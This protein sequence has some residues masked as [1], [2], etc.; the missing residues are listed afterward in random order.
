[1]VVSVSNRIFPPPPHTYTPASGICSSPLVLSLDLDGPAVP[2]IVPIVTNAEAI[3]VNQAWAGHPRLL[4]Q[5]HDPQL[6]PR[7]AP[8]ARR[9]VADPPPPP[10][11]GPD[12][13]GFVKYKGMLNARDDVRF[14]ASLATAP[15][16]TKKK[17]SRCVH[18]PHS[19]CRELCRVLCQSLAPTHLPH[20]FPPTRQHILTQKPCSFPRAVVLV[21]VSFLDTHNSRHLGAARHHPE[22]RARAVSN[23][24]RGPGFGP[25]H[26]P[27]IDSLPNPVFRFIQGG[28]PLRTATLRIAEA[29][30]WC[31]STPSCTCTATSTSLLSI[32]R[33]SLSSKPPHDVCFLIV[34]T[35]VTC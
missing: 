24:D 16:K 30:A 28:R 26:V 9:K 10:H 2:Q 18:S 25:A 5:S 7:P 19:L 15:K 31:R 29:E 13:F 27:P 11:S 32:S 21:G 17:R 23:T 8:P 33:A 14:W 20:I 12:G 3:A 6:Q 4:L 34:L 35:C 22:T 1:M